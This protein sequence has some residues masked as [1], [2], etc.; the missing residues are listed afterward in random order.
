MIVEMK[1]ITL[2]C[3][4]QSRATT[5]KA[6][7]ELGVVHI[8]GVEPREHA[9][10]SRA[11]EHLE[12]ATHALR[13][14]DMVELNDDDRK[15]AR[16]AASE[17][18]LTG[19]Q[20]V[21]RVLELDTKRQDLV[22]EIDR[23]ETECRRIAPF[24]DFDPAQIL[25]LRRRGLDVGLFRASVRDSVEAPSDNAILSV[26][27]SD[28]NYRF[29]VV[30]GPAATLATD[31]LPDHWDEMELPAESLSHLQ[32]HVEHRSEEL[33]EVVADLKQWWGCRDRIQHV[34]TGTSDEVRMLEV[35]EGMSEEGA[36]AW[37]EGFAPA[38]Q[39]ADL[40]KAAA[41]NGWGLVLAE[42]DPDEAVPTLVKYPAWV[43][44]IKAVFQLLEITPGYN[45]AD[46]S[47]AF[48]L[49]FSFFF[50]ML[51]GDAGYGLLFLI[52]TWI[53]RRKM[54]KAPSYPFTLLY[55]L[56]TVTIVWGVLSGNAFGITAWPAPLNSLKLQWLQDQKNVMGLSFFIGA[57]HLSLA[58]IWNA[59]VRWPALEALAQIGWVCMTWTMFYVAQAMVLG[60]TIPTWIFGVFGVGILLIVLFMTPVKRLK[61]DWINHAI[62]PLD[63]VSNFVDVVSYI[64]LFA[65]GMATLAV[66]E[67]FNKM[68][69]GVGFGSIPTG[70]GA[71]LILLAGHTLNILLFGLGVLVHGVR[72][73]TLEFSKHKEMQWSGFPYKPFSRSQPTAT[74]E[75]KE[76]ATGS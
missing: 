59:I 5:V 55:V 32:K 28:E 67:S 2:L 48:L 10:L 51:A 11:R 65:V 15:A 58:R 31:A 72:L 44:P 18:D 49:F 16:L 21:Q 13:A 36:V 4:A 3:M 14:F 23:L 63:I 38:T 52:M 56:S 66:A 64:R 41:A 43:R 68:A 75:S 57:V 35:R 19:P 22:E 17:S 60:G 40:E 62:L 24:G 8:T 69:M 34:A 46:I 76:A 25:D 37:I 12:R 45:E 20:L 74:D 30:A 54:P 42:P 33:S 29:F 61:T 39:T 70:F 47:V 7:R 73:N 1:K 53:G 27:G 50:G 71:A 9:D 26:V 6:L